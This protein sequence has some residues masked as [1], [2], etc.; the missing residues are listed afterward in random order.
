MGGSFC[1]V[2]YGNGG[3]GR[4]GANALYITREQAC[5]RWDTRHVPEHELSGLT[6]QDRRRD[7]ALYLNEHAERGRGQ[8]TDYRVVLSFEQGREVS[9]QKALDLA[10]EFLARSRF[11]DN[12][13][14]MAVHRN[15]AHQHVHILLSARRTDGRKLHL[16][17]QDFRSFDKVWARIYERERGRAWEKSHLEK[18]AAVAAWKRAYGRLRARG[19]T[20]AQVKAVI[21]PDPKNFNNL[22]REVVHAR[23]GEREKVRL[24]AHLHRARATLDGVRG[25]TG[26]PHRRDR[27]ADGASE[28]AAGRDAQRTATVAAARLRHLG[29]TAQSRDDTVERDVRGLA[30]DL[31]R[32][33]D[34][35]L[36]RSLTR[37]H[38]SRTPK[39][40]GS[41]TVGS[42]DFIA[43]SLSRD[44]D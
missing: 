14:L 19:M 13:A 3:G 12:P 22:K 27:A 21:G 15:T 26:P 42:A 30:R 25:R 6:E 11:R 2:T 34:T 31:S 36:Q 38:A 23:R 17:R 7:A 8:R 35:P 41:Q 40:T 28:R 4:T 29:R 44:R 20:P 24:G 10:R 43:G 39:R 16:D 9:D 1:R 32:P 33:L 5:T 37:L 18:A